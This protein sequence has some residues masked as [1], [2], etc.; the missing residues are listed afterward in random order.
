MK[1]KRNILKEYAETRIKENKEQFWDNIIDLNKI[2]IE[3]LKKQ[4][5]DLELKAMGTGFGH[6]FYDGPNGKILKEEAKYTLPYDKTVE[7]LKRL[8]KLE[9]WQ[10]KMHVDTNSA[11]NN[12][13]LIVVFAEISQNKELIKDTMLNC[14]WTIAQEYPKTINGMRWTFMSFDPMF[15]DDVT[16]EALSHTFLYHITPLYNRENIEKYGL[17]PKSE[18]IFFKYPERVHLI[19]GDTTQEE[20]ITI[21]QQLYSGNVNTKNDG[22]YVL[23]ALYTKLIPSNIRFYYDP[24]YSHGYYTKDAIPPTCMKAIEIYNYKTYEIKKLYKDE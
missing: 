5:C 6:V 11:A 23:F 24:R 9:D 1:K 21:G 18:N 13:Q 17:I 19:K 22:Q 14:G 4:Y 15:Q 16:E 8:F 10:T 7:E 20:I 12:I 2:P 3:K